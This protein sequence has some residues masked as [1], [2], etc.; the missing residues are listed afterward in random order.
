MFLLK[1]AKN[2]KLEPHEKIY[3]A[4]PKITKKDMKALKEPKTF[5]FTSSRSQYNRF[6]A[7]NFA[8]IEEHIKFR[9]NFR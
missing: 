6:D 2:S 1:K 9:V 4:C 5:L 3:F 8:I 7:H